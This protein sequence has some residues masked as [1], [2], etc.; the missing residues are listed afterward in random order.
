MPK[1]VLDGEGFWGSR[2]LR[3]CPVWI[4]REYPYLYPLADCNGNFEL[5]IPVILGKL[6]ANRPD[7]S[8]RKLGLVFETFKKE[9]LAFVWAVARRQYIHWTRSERRGRLPRLSRRSNKYERKLAPP[10]PLEE[11][12]AY[13]HTFGETLDASASDGLAL[14]TAKATAKATDRATEKTTP[15]ASPAFRALTDWLIKTFQETIG[16]KPT[17][18]KKD[19]IALALLKKENSNLTDNEIK[20]R[21]VSFLDSNTTWLQGWQLWKFCKDFD[22]FIEGPVIRPPTQQEIAEKDAA[23]GRGPR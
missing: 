14:A 13:L 17:W 4:R 15:P 6:K 19:F 18:R 1:R 21:F 8:I 16:K 5:D 11:Y 3:R 22:S 23:V 10:L 2:K 20:I 12:K 9:G 7:L